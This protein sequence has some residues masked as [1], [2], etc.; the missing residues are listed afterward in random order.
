MHAD[1]GGEAVVTN[2]S[3]GGAAEGAGIE[4]GDVLRATS[5]TTMAMTYPTLNLM[6]GGALS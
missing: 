1:V 4:L 3:P 2:I 6:F 5:A